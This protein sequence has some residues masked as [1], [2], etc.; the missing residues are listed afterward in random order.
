MVIQVSSL[1][2]KCKI[3]G[4]EVAFTL[5]K[6]LKV[7]VKL[8]ILFE[9]CHCKFERT[10]SSLKDT[11]PDLE[12]ILQKEPFELYKKIVE[13]KHLSEQINPFLKV[14]DPFSSKLTKSNGIEI[15]NKGK[16]RET[17]SES[18][19]VRLKET[20]SNSCPDIP[21]HYSKHG[22]GKTLESDK[23]PTK[24]NL[25]TEGSSQIS[26]RDGTQSRS[27]RDQTS[28]KTNKSNSR[29][30]REE[31]QNTIGEIS[32]SPPDA[33][34]GSFSDS[35]K[36]TSP[37]EGQN[38]SSRR[39]PSESIKK[40]VVI[41]TSPLFKVSG[42]GGTF[43][44]KS[45]Q[46]LS[47]KINVIFNG[48]L[49]EFK[50]SFSTIDKTLIEFHSSYMKEPYML[51]EKIVNK[52]I[53]SKNFQPFFNPLQL[54]IPSTLAKDRLCEIYFGKG[55]FVPNLPPNFIEIWNMESFLTKKK[56]YESHTLF[57]ITENDFLRFVK[58][59]ENPIINEY[60]M[61]LN[62]HV[63]PSEFNQSA[64]K[65]PYWA[66]IPNELD[67]EFL[68]KTYEEQVEVLKVKGNGCYMPSNLIEAGLDQ[69]LNFV[70]KRVRNSKIL[71]RCAETIGNSNVHA[72]LF[73]GNNDWDIEIKNGVEKGYFEGILPVWRLDLQS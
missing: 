6:D 15:P 2:S 63:S 37:R 60:R 66:L 35:T 55:G 1:A 48:H 17:R 51:F 44:L 9:H 26:P 4:G 11:M 18:M 38:V 3:P 22:H 12:V 67:E 14:I 68:H 64:L 20:H 40:A 47:M 24:I 72:V 56:V 32:S 45:D 62:F 39:R 13:G 30:P 7:T 28:P 52:N 21:I 46:S 61:Q 53:F 33:S 23:R 29:S 5:D 19:P 54:E 41:E 49:C 71:I 69:T 57:L 27:R 34:Q 42:G 25:L 43:F 31:K 58:A 10:L 16:T 8:T 36:S 73:K 59:I 70:D 65:T 50:K